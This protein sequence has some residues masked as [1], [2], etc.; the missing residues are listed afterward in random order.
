MW[1]RPTVTGTPPSA[2]CAAAAAAAC[3][4]GDEHSS[5]GPPRSYWHSATAV[6]AE[7]VVVFGGTA[8]GS[9]LFNDTHVMDAGQC[10]PAHASIV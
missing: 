4:R 5:L 6:S 2:R 7:R 3:G 10:A 1:T 9:L 8:G